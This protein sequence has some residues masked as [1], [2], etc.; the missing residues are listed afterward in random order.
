[1]SK[2]LML[3]DCKAAAITPSQNASKKSAS[4]SFAYYNKGKSAG[5]ASCR[6]ATSTSVDPSAVTVIPSRRLSP[7]KSRPPKNLK[8]TVLVLSCE[9]FMK[10]LIRQVAVE[11]HLKVLVPI[12]CEVADAIT[13]ARLVGTI[14]ICENAIVSET[15]PAPNASVE[16]GYSIFHQK[17]PSIILKRMCR[18]LYDAVCHMS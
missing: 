5:T 15:M 13:N 9:L 18:N 8:D 4:V 16:G 12:G 2:Q 11:G 1:M 6:Q 7:P 10:H 17:I 3:Q 14:G